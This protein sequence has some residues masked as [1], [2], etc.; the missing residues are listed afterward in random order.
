MSPAEQSR[1]PGHMRA[2]DNDRGMVADLLSAAYA[3]GRLTREEH[4]Q[5]LQQ[6]MEAKTF[7]DLRGITTDLVP[8]TN[9]GRSVGAFTSS[10]VHI[11]RGNASPDADLTFAIFGGTERKGVW[12]ARKNISNLTLFGGTV[13]DFREATFESD[14]VEVTLFCMFGGVDIKVPEG[15]NVRN[16]TF[17][18]F[19][20]SDVKHTRPSPGGPTIVVKGLVAFGGV[21]VRGPK[22]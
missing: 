18:V 12:H 15:V 11:D 17:A 4:D 13:L 9:P 6:A 7:D 8:A 20:G 1:Q 2:G 19:G 10:G 14:V 3:E 21:D 5:R 22:S 16:E